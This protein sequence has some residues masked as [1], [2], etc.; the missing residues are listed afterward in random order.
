MGDLN[1]SGMSDLV[2]ADDALK[3][4]HIL[5]Q[6]SEKLNQLKQLEVNLDRLKTVEMQRIELA[7]ETLLKEIKNLRSEV[8]NDVIEAEL[9]TE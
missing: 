1:R 5:I 6:I 3:R 7:K 8:K 4:K 9:V 2:L